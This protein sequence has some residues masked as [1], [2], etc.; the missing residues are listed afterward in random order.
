MGVTRR[1][2]GEAG[3]VVVLAGLAVLFAR[4][5]LL[6]GAAG[7]AGW[8]L[9]RQY[10][11]VR[12]VSKVSSDL[13]VAQSASKGALR[14]GDESRVLLDAELPQPAPFTIDFEA[15]PPVGLEVRESD[16]DEVTENDADEVAETG[17]RASLSAGQR[18][19]ATAFAVRCPLAGAFEFDRPTASVTDRTGRFRATFPAGSE[20]DLTVN[21]RGPR[22]VHV[23]A[24]GE[25]VQ[26][27]F[28]EY[29][30]DDTGPGFEL[31]GIRS[32]VPGDEVNHID[33]NATARLGEPHVRKFETTT[34]RASV[35]LVDCRSS[36][37]DGAEGETKFDY[38]RQVA[39]AVV[40]HARDRGDPL[41]L[42]AVGDD[43][44]LVDQSPTTTEE[45][46]RLIE[47]RLRAL[48]PEEITDDSGKR[49]EAISP[50]TARRRAQRLHGEDSAFADRLEPFFA[51]ADPYVERVTDDPLFRVARTRL[52]QLHGAVTVVA[53]TDDTRR[54]ETRE[55]TKIARRGD[56]H[57]RAFLTPTALFEDEADLEA[58]YDR[59][60]DFERF[61]RELANLDR[62][63]AFEVGPGDRVEALLAANRMQ[64]RAR[65]GA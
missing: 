4:P 12:S 56:D 63:T 35:L 41:A 29:A 45:G 16:T 3:L 22:N 50:A 62:V 13:A 9:T 40:E 60:A 18:A 39:L 17:L 31:T 61:R 26:A 43:G 32:Y 58:S 2:W 65:R 44:L 30:S 59:Y 15:N 36:M 42:Y 10:A 5:I 7:V 33:W 8:L 28:G 6:V 47:R 11:F 57:L 38:V 52:D 53:L 55:V 25:A 20:L 54:T 48:E 23:G 46:Y 64:K 27:P 37:A 21:P 14:V 24:G 34:E 51:D 49:T 19:A 1:F